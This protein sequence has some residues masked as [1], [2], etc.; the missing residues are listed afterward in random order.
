MSLKWRNE[1]HFVPKRF[2][3]KSLTIFRVN[4]RDLITYVK[5]H[6]RTIRAQPT[7]L[8]LMLAQRERDECGKFV[9]GESRC[10]FIGY[11]TIAIHSSLYWVDLA[12]AAAA[13]KNGA[14][15]AEQTK[16]VN[17]DRGSASESFA[18]F[19]TKFHSSVS[20][21]RARAIF[22][23]VDA[24]LP[25]ITPHVNFTF[26]WLQ[27]EHAAEPQLNNNHYNVI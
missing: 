20:I 22:S 27:V 21:V 14:Q 6:L 12:T 15:N 25:S 4:A 17:K 23:R 16:C 24:K 5:H 26:C 1:Y 11:A 3:C 13:V 2:E 9:F 18:L 7:I 10:D 8:V 19:R